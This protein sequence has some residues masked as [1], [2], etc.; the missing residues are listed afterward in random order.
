[1]KKYKIGPLFTPPVV[2]ECHGPLAT[3]HEPGSTGGA[4]WPGGS[5]DPET[6]H[7]YVYSQTIPAMLGLVKPDPK[8]STLAY[9]QGSARA[10]GAAAPRR[11]AGGGGEGGGGINMQGLPLLKPPY[12]RITAFDMDQGEILWQVA[13]GDTP[14]NIKNNPALKGLNIPRTGRPGTIGVV[15][16]DAGYRGRVGFG[17]LLP[18]GRA[19]RC[20]APTIR[21][22]ATRS[23][24][25]ICPLRKADRR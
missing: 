12:A 5:W 13:H 24:R 7:L 9:V 20:C 11:G 15:T 1:M 8:V 3:I 25:C 14:D 22:P 17:P 2:S 4:N 23:A 6:H 19:G 21:R 18:S 16:K 10:P